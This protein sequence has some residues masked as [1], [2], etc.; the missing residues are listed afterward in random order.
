MFKTIKELTTAHFKQPSNMYIIIPSF[1]LTYI[2]KIE[3][4]I[5]KNQN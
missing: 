2:I 3:K 5:L 4:L 1:V